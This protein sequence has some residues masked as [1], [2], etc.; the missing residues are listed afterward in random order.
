MGKRVPIT[1]FNI[2]RHPKKVGERLLEDHGD[3]L[4]QGALSVA[5]GGAPVTLASA[6]EVLGHL[7]LEAV[8][9]EMATEAMKAM[10]A[11]YTPVQQAAFKAGVDAQYRAILKRLGR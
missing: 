8:R 3:D 7:A 1:L 11:T 2:F 5:V 10:P 9:D 4:L 6:G